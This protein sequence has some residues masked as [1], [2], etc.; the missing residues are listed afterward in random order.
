[1]AIILYNPKAK[2]TQTTHRVEKMKRRL[3]KRFETVDVIDITQAADL[4]STLS[5][6]QNHPFV[7]LMGGDGTVHHFINE[8]YDL[9]PL[10]Y[11]VYLSPMGSGNDFYRS[12]KKY[13]GPTQLFQLQQDQNTHYF[14]NGM[15]IGI[16]GEIGKNVNKDPQKRKLT[17]FKEAIKAIVRYQPDSVVV[18]IDGKSHSFADA[19]LVVASNG[20]YFGSGMRIAPKANPESSLLDVIIAYNVS[21]L[22]VL[23]IFLTIYLGLHTRFK[24]HVFSKQASSLKVHFKTPKVSQMDGECFENIKSLHVT[25]AEKKAAF[26]IFR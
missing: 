7:V 5:Q 1:M 25:I 17:Y 14:I 24:K 8:I 12:L 2:N 3:L 11:P 6:S 16:D 18:E 23:F 22:K 13:H 10:P 9:L 26:R 4:K 19:Y 20:Q 21:R 15:G